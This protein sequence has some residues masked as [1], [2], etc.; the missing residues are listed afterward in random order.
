MRRGE[1][2]VEFI[3]DYHDELHSFSMLEIYLFSKLI[4][5]IDLK[6]KDSNFNLSINVNMKYE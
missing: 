6:L 5:A 2:I 4:Q 1:K 3:D